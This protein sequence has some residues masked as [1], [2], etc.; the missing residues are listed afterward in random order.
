VRRLLFL[1]LLLIATTVFADDFNTSETNTSEDT[2]LFM[3]MPKVLYVSYK[4]TP[5]RVFKGEIFSITIK[6]LSTLQDTTDITYEF[7]NY[8][9]LESFG[10]IPYRDSDD[11]YYY[12][13][14]Y[15]LTTQ[16]DAKLPDITA[17]PTTY[18]EAPHRS[19]TLKGEQLNVITLNPKKDFSNIIANSFEL[20]DYKTTTY[21]NKH[22]I[23]VFVA[24]AN[25]C[26]I[27][28]LHFNNVFKQGIESVSEDYLESKITYYIII[29]KEIE[30][31]SFSYF[32]LKANKYL[33]I[34][35]P[36]I[37]NDD[38]VTTQSDLKPKDQSKERLKM[39]IASI[40]ALVGFI[41]ILWRKKYI[42]LVFILLPLGYVAYIGIPSKQLCIKVDSNI[43][44]LPVHNGTIFETTKKTIY[45]QKEGSVKDF[46]KVKL[47]TDKI[48]W[49]RNED[50]CSY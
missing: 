11:K 48:G 5:K 17:T 1:V 10:T 21:D 34:N 6:A 27:K 30:N 9:G 37:V 32:N 40:I 33:N 45:L 18:D 41:F 24:T 14:F 35:I 13:T 29:N 28:A 50:I 31:F 19:T 20:V 8:Y 15:F 2:E 47:Q 44:L 26:D 12:D 43:Y 36:V 38:S 3:H 7:S 42:Y 25:N 16:S 39:Y 46:V 22:N 23:I 4:E 49:V